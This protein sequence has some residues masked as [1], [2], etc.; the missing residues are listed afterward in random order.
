MLVEVFADGNALRH[1]LV[2]TKEIQRELVEADDVEDHP[3]MP[4]SKQIPS[5][6][7]D[8]TTFTTPLELAAV[9]RDAEGHERLVDLHADLLEKGLEVRVGSSVHDD[10]AGVDIDVG[11]APSPWLGVR[12][13]S[14]LRV[15]FE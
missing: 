14:K 11:F 6:S 15:L 8:T 10:K 1:F 9:P 12:V 2:F 3:P 13:A 4:G 5:L 7:E